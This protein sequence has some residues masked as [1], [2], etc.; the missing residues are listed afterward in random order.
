MKP[1]SEQI[2]EAE[3]RVMV[4]DALVRHRAIDLEHVVRQ[5]ARQGLLQVALTTGGLLLAASVLSVLAHR[6]PRGA[7]LAATTSRL[8][9]LPWLRMAAFIWP[10]LARGLE[11]RPVEGRTVRR[12]TAR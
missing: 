1:L 5:R 11:C 8:R 3:Q 7:P 10:M 12:D 9:R 6:P 4:H 2:E